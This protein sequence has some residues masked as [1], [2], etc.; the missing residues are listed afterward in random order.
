M[1]FINYLKQTFQS[2]SLAKNLLLG[3]AIGL[4]LIGFFLYKADAPNPEWPRFWIIR[5]LLLVPF[6]GAM[7]GL[8]YTS[9]EP[10]RSKSGWIKAAS[11]IL[12]LIV[13]LIGLFMG[14]VLGLDGTYWN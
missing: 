4:A 10:W 8:F 12:C 14:T 13:F 7:G 3:A 1:S 2:P 9:M 6:A 11:Y 5:P